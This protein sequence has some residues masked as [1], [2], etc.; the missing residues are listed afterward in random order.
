MLAGMVMAFYFYGCSDDLLTMGTSTS[1]MEPRSIMSTT[2]SVGDDYYWF[3][4]KKNLLNG[5]AYKA[6][7]YLFRREK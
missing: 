5:E 7:H 6:I 4:G 2:D 3:E 1:M